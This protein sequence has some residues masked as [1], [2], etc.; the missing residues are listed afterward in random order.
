MFVSI[1]GVRGLKA[2]AIGW[3]WGV[4]VLLISACMFMLLDVVKVAII[5]IKLYPTKSRKADL[6]VRLAKKAIKNRVNE[7]IEKA[8]KVLYMTLGLVAWRKA[9]ASRQKLLTGNGS[10]TVDFN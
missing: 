10:S 7:N 1:Y 6:K 5:R 3:G 4:I 2:T 9:A 8:R